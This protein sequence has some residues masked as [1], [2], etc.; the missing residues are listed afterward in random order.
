MNT[1][2]DDEDSDYI[3]CKLLDD[4]LRPVCGSSISF[5]SEDSR[6]DFNDPG[7][8]N[9]QDGDFVGSPKNTKLIQV[10]LL[11]IK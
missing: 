6:S 9:S 2:D 11:P 8:P 4:P 7:P 10:I 5:E 3:T 1:I